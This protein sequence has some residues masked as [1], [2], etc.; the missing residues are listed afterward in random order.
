MS[1]GP[2][3]TPSEGQVSTAEESPAPQSEAQPSSST[4]VSKT[5]STSPTP[6]SDES[7]NSVAE[8]PRPRIRIGSQRSA[9]DLQHLAKK[10][11][12]QEQTPPESQTAPSDNEQ[13]EPPAPATPDDPASAAET[14]ADT[15][16]ELPAHEAAATEERTAEVNLAAI[17]QDVDAEIEQALGDVSFEELIDDGS[18][19]HTGEQLEEGSR[20][21]AIV[22]KT[23]REDVFLSIGGRHEGIAPLR[24]FKR[25]PGPG[26]M[27]DVAVTGYNAEDGLYELSVPGAAVAVADWADLHEGSIVDA[28]V[29]GANTGGLECMVQSIRGFIPAS[30]IA[31]YRVDNMSEFIN[32][33]LQCVVTEANPRRRNLVLSHRAVLE[34]EREQERQKL[35]DELQVG[36]VRE[37]T[38]T[39]VRDF[40]AFVDLGGIDGLLHISKM[41]WDHIGHPSEMFDVGHKIRVKIEKV[42]AQSGKIGL[43]HR[44][45]L[46]HPWTNVEQK[47][48]P[49]SVVTG[50]VSRLAKFGAFVKLAPGIEGLIHISELAHHRVFSVNNVLNEGQEVEVK[51]LSVDPEG[52]R[53][54]LSL[55]AT[56]PV[57]QPEE[58]SEAD[59][60]DEP[61]RELAVPRRKKPLKGGRDKKSGGEQFGLKW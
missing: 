26:D 58:K 21:K 59:T 19:G 35:L 47:F 38:V 27:L 53:I 32:H 23:H 42:D 61:P 25:P 44:D 28:R 52:Q 5:A 22:V 54:A 43:S 14:P 7:A 16:A 51:V 40:G 12:S 9:S 24:Q 30:Q 11:A 1:T 41:S 15:A 39:K 60:A 6:A 4:S 46:E 36:D 55:K 8:R 2:T 57:P 13:V 50:Q 29:T 37:G 49:N 45:L 17:D 33:K 18:A 34:R 56:Q 10:D 20:H 48:Q 31:M 3:E